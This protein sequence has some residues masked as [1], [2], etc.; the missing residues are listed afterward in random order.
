MFEIT[1]TP[2]MGNRWN[3]NAMA[4]YDK[5]FQFPIA[6]MQRPKKERE[7]GESLSM[8]ILHASIAHVARKMASGHSRWPEDE[9]DRL[10]S[11]YEYGNDVKSKSDHQHYAFAA[12]CY[13]NVRLGGGPSAITKLIGAKSELGGTFARLR[14]DIFWS[15]VHDEWHPIR[16]RAL[17]GIY[18]GVGADR[19][20]WLA[21]S[22]LCALAAGFTKLDGVD[23][24]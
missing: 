15:M 18:A 7:T 17:V 11:E 9:V 2:H 3:C 21:W 1:T 8:V 4:Q 23:H 6:V 24:Y 10:H 19:A 12:A 16:I 20:K 5:Y 14:T 13:L 22:R